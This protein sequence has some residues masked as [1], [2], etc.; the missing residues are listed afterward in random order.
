M[1]NLAWHS[2]FAL[3]QK[4]VVS[5]ISQKMTCISLNLVH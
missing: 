4:T 3:Q 2:S 1:P 5:D